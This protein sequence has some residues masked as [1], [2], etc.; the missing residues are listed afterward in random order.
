MFFIAR[1]KFPVRDHFY[2]DP[3]K[4]RSGFAEKFVQGV[5]FKA[6]NFKRFFTTCLAEPFGKGANSLHLFYWQFHS[7]AIFVLFILE[8]ILHSSWN[9]WI[10]CSSFQAIF[11]PRNKRI[12]KGRIYFVK[13]NYYKLLLTNTIYYIYTIEICI[14]KAGSKMT[15]PS[16]FSS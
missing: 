13:T 9:R 11:L 8:L 3:L 12:I 16:L 10:A 6:T 14:K 7:P 4:T 1:M 5:R 2:F 15:P